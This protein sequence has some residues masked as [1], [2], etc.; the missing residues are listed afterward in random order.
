M[1]IQFK[2]TSILLAALCAVLAIGCRDVSEVLDLDGA[3]ASTDTDTGTGTDVGP[4]PPPMDAMDVV[5]VIDD[6]GSMSQEQSILATSVFHLISTLTTPRPDWP[7][8]AVDDVRFAVI[9]TNMGLSADGA[10]GDDLWPGGDA[11]AACHDRGDDGV[12]RPI[13]V[14]DVTIQSGVIPC[15]DVPGQCPP[16][17]TC[18]TDAEA[19]G[20]T[21]QISGDNAVDCPA[22]DAAWVGTSAEDPD[23]ALALEVACLSMQG[24]SGCGFEQQL[25]AAARATQREDQASFLR[26]DAGLGIVVVSDEDDCTM[27]DNA[28]LFATEEVAEQALK[29]VNIAC[30]EHPEYLHD[31]AWF[32]DT[33]AAAKGG[34][35]AAVFFA[36]IVGVPGGGGC[37]GPGNALGGC[38]D[39]DGMQLVP[40]EDES[41]WKYTPACSRSAGAT[42]VTMAYPGRRYVELA[43]AMGANAY[44]Y[45]IC[46]ES[47]MPAMEAFAGILAGAVE[48]F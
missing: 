18:E 33:F 7:Y 11:P 19:G 12:F 34:V 2:K 9:T 3:D 24:T 16:G 39:Q 8:P 21:C 44:V 36:A 26:E 28:G 48:K 22:I 25:G 5:F 6:S 35:E 40:A 1:A 20:S 29:K 23:D 42:E 14:D 47:W 10:I 37:E 43:E 15:W 45:S 30:G 38:L 4:L 17:W 32:V 41:G 13:V 31:T 46:N 27:A